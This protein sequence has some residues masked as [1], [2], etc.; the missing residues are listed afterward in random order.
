LLDTR[1]AV[2]NHGSSS[3]ET[4]DGQTLH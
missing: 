1:A 4:S 3:A 2:T